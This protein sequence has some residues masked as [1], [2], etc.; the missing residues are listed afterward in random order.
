MTPD[1]QYRAVLAE[2]RERY[3]SGQPSVELHAV[4][5]QL[6]HQ[7]TVAMIPIHDHHDGDDDPDA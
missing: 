4:A 6:H 2:I 3:R 7:L 5:R 1:A